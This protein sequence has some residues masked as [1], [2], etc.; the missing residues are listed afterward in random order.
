MPGHAGRQARHDTT[1][2]GR[3]RTILK[4][5]YP[6]GYPYSLTR[7]FSMSE[8]ERVSACVLDSACAFACVFVYKRLLTAANKRI[9]VYIVPRC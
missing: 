3:V 7:A 8:C 4:D 5:L 2:T 6:L 9:F 1:G